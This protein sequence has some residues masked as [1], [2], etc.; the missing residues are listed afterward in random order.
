M[1]GI[2]IVKL[3]AQD[4]LRLKV[5]D[6]TPRGN[7][8]RIT[9]ANSSGKSSCLNAIMAAIGGKRL[10]P[11]KPVREGADEAIIEVDLGQYKV[12]QR[13]TNGTKQPSVIV[14]AKDGSRF[15]SPQDLL[16]KLLGD[17]TFDPLVFSRMKPAH[18]LNEI[19][20]ITGL[21]SEI[22]DIDVANAADYEARAAINRD[23]KQA[24]A[25][26]EQIAIPA[27]LPDARA[28]IAE[29]AEQMEKATAHNAN[30]STRRERRI[31]AGEKVADL[32][33]RAGDIH[34]K[35]PGIILEIHK[36]CD[37]RVK[38]LQRQIEEVKAVAARDVRK[39]DE[40]AD[41]NVALLSIEADVIKAKLDAA[42]PLGEPVDTLA[43][44]EALANAQH[45]NAGFDAL[46]NRAELLAQAKE[47]SAK[48]ASLTEVMELR[49]RRKAEII[50]AAKLPVPGLGFGDGCV[51]LNG[52]PLEQAS[53]AEQLRASV[54]VAM[55]ANPQLRILRITDGSLLDAKSMAILEEMAGDADFQIWLECVSDDANAVGIV[56]SEGVVVADNQG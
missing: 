54:A 10:A 40:A 17:L 28:N 9:G 6:I 33:A 18:Q 55:A 50:A 23:A 14:E 20:R 53:S 39:S 42:E 35:Q 15:R 49:N 48:S 34:A 46:D 56:M 12:T 43:I 27:D 30:I 26:A 8:V 4:F 19:R 3:H 47:L 22:D 36:R 16:D 25:T 13:F 51:T 2:R 21:G 5:V 45:V 7:V 52:I 38:E 11:A 44:K 24:K 37:E 41:C 32:R 1:A 31:A 29:L